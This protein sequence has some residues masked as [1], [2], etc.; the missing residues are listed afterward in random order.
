MATGAR[1]GN[2]LGGCKGE[3]AH[4]VYRMGIYV[5]LFAQSLLALCIITLRY[6][7]IELFTD[8]ENVINIA[9]PAFTLLICTAIPDGLHGIY[10]NFGRSINTQTFGFFITIFG[11]WCVGMPIAFILS[12]Y[13]GQ[14]TYY[15]DNIPETHRGIGIRGIW[16][17]L[18]ISTT[19][20][21]TLY[22]ILVSRFQ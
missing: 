5:T 12:L 8:K 9:V 7:I 6:K 20:I 11:F 13:V 19:V 22:T 2:F 3:V 17:S 10:S 1:I 14:H 21:S 18:I 4:H 16:L 15:I